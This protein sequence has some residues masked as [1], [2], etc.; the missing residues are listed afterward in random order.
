M[1]EKQSQFERPPAKIF[2]S[3]PQEIK[4]LISEGFLETF[5]D[6]KID[7]ISDELMLEIETAQE[8]KSETIEKIIHS[9]NKLTNELIKAYGAQPFDIPPQNIFILPAATLSKLSK[10]NIA[11]TGGFTS[12]LDQKIFLRKEEID[13]SPII[14]AKLII[15]EMIHLKGF[16][17]LRVDV[18]TDEKDLKSISLGLKRFGLNVHGKPKKETKEQRSVFRGLE[19]AVTTEL[20]KITL[21]K[22]L[23]ES[24]IVGIS[25]ELDFVNSEKGKQIFDLMTERLGNKDFYWLKLIDSNQKLIIRNSGYEGQRAV[26]SYVTDEISK[27]QGI[28]KEKVFELFASSHFKGYLISIARL[29]IKTFGEDAWY[30]LSTMSDSEDSALET[31]QKLKTI[32]QN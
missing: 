12:P 31:L 20:D 4:D 3:A 23:M 8:K 24:D 2:G 25:E 22:F 10:S 1:S 16:T 6:G 27:K 15:H 29:V 32:A 7:D 26:L 5:Q 14:A 28:S 19:E 11:N 13:L 17:S 9:A 21:N 30:I 18:I